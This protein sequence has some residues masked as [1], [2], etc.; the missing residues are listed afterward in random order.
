MI[1]PTDFGVCVTEYFTKHLAGVRNLSSNTIKSYRDTFCL[2]LQ[3]LSD[4]MNLRP[5]KIKLWSS[6]IK[7]T[8]SN[9]RKREY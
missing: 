6:I 5:E 3:F 9:S 7:V 4:E 1:K 2:L 8:Q